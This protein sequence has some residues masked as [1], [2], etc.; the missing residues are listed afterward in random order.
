MSTS[1][2]PAPTREPG[3]HLALVGP[4]AS[5]KSA[6]A[7]ELATR[8]L[9]VG[10]RVEIVSMDS[11]QVYRRM[12]IGTAK[13]NR[14]ERERVVHHLIDLVDPTEEW[15]VAEFVAAANAAIDGIERRGGR[16]LLVG[17]TGLYVQAVVDD[18]R[19]PGRYPA[20]ADALAEEPDTAALHARLQ[21]L[22]PD[23][24]ARI[25]A[26]NRRRI[27]RALEVT[28]GSGRP[29]ST[30][31]PG[32]GTYEQTPYVLC[33]LRVERSELAERIERRFRRQLAAGWVDEVAALHTAGRLSRTAAQA[34]GYRELL[35]HLDG[36]LSRD[37]A[38]ELAI[39]RTRQ[40]AVRQIRWFR[41]DP[42][43]AWTDPTDVQAAAEEID[44]LWRKRVEAA[45]G[46]TATVEASHA[47]APDR[48]GRTSAD[49]P[50]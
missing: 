42:R 12:D 40:F 17:G 25:E 34:L 18:L 48:S 8:R 5:G 19:I 32:L 11:M 41:R 44:A 36:E 38:I 4:T 13:A 39:T 16:A 9:A 15:S 2:R 23:A 14:D 30:W 37:E 29:F 28:L 35:R 27:V 46:S 1:E 47:A 24:A 45:T 49:P 7:I 3:R 26:G 31:G 10:E 6:I 50:R 20:Q 33:G 21:E 43:I 22:D